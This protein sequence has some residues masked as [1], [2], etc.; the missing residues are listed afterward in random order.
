M[1]LHVIQRG[2][3]RMA[4]FADD[5]DRTVYLALLRSSLPKLGCHLHAYCLMTN[6]IHLLMTPASGK[7]CAALMHRLSQGYAQYFNKKHGRTGTLWEGRFRSSLVATAPYIV[8]CYRY[9]ER[10]PVRAGLVPHPLAYRW[11]SHR[12]N[13]GLAEDP[14]LSP[15]EEWLVIGP[16]R[17]RQLAADDG[18]AD[19]LRSIRE[20][21]NGGLPLGL[22]QS[23]QGL[24]DAVRVRPGKPGRPAK[25]SAPVPDLGISGDGAS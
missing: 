3:N 15:T 8:A 10:N 23:C 21:L 7:A 22:Q 13:C 4:C 2:N 6:H 16:A 14:L 5:A 11:S 24:P 25:K 19:E 9:I 20:A 12:G 18:T 17:Y 1:P